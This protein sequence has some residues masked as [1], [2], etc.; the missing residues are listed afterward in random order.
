MKRWSRARRGR[1]KSS[2]M[3]MEP[4]VFK[5]C[6]ELVRHVHSSRHGSSPSR[7]L[8]PGQG[9]TV[10]GAVTT[11][12]EQSNTLVTLIQTKALTTT[13]QW[14]IQDLINKLIKGFITAD[15]QAVGITEFEATDP[16]HWLGA[17]FFFFLSTRI[18]KAK[19]E[20]NY[21]QHT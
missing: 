16:T 11:R 3:E 18:F 1:A 8:L 21:D 15:Y 6:R 4:N 10:S 19:Q 13:G 20:L 17:C 9:H 5:C 2:N 14:S 7:T 12:A